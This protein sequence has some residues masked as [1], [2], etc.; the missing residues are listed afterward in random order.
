M[1]PFPVERTYKEKFITKMMWAFPSALSGRITGFRS[2]KRQLQGTPHKPTS[3]HSLSD[4][5][6]LI[7]VRCQSILN[8]KFEFASHILS[9][10]RMHNISWNQQR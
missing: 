10:L 9:Q 1:K 8:T 3:T 5:G 7:C 4:G 2:S 6:E